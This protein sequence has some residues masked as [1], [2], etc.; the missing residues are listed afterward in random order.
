MAYTPPAPTTVNFTLQ[1]YTPPSY[2][3]VSFELEQGLA[4]VLGWVMIAG[5]WKTVDEMKVCIS[6]VW[7]P[8][9]E[10]K[11]CIGGTWKGLV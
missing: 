4:I 6:G 8:V 3:A 2:N 5:V 9:S 11:V 1:A 7:K 10:V